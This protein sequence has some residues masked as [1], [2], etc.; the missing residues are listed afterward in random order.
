MNYTILQYLRLLHKLE[1][2][3]IHFGSNTV[4][5]N[6]CTSV[7]T[8]LD[9]YYKIIK[10]QNFAIVATI[11]NPR[12]NFNMFYNLYQ[13]SD[14]NNIYRSRIRKQFVDTFVQY[15]YREQ[16]LQAVEVEAQLPS[17]KANNSEQDNSELDLFK[18]R[19]LSDFES[20]YTK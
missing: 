5:G 19:G 11:Y 4:L 7:Y 16:A 12:F 1:L 10:K 17:K 15:S 8:K 20:E 3:R 2:L 6:A 13:D 18:A 14:S 9:K